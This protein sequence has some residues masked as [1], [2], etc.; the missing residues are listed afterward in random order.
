M[1]NDPPSSFSTGALRGS[2]LTAW[3]KTNLATSFYLCVLAVSHDYNA[4]HSARIL[5]LGFAPKSCLRPV[6]FMYLVS[7][8]SCTPTESVLLPVRA[9]LAFWIRFQRVIPQRWCVLA[10]A[11]TFTLLGVHPSGVSP[12]LELLLP[13]GGIPFYLFLQFQGFTP[14]QNWLA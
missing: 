12:Q 6:P 9:V 8:G 4:F 7:S 13:F 5:C 10:C 2:P 1:Q 3:V 14:Q 11:S